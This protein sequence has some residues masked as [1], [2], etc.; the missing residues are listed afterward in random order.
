MRIHGVAI[1]VPLLSFA[2]PDRSSRLWQ[3]LAD[4]NELSGLSPAS[5]SPAVNF[6][7]RL[8]GWLRHRPS[9]RFGQVNLRPKV[10][11]LRSDSVTSS[12]LAA[13]DPAFDVVLQEGFF[14]SPK[15]ASKPYAVYIDATGS[16]VA[17]H[18]PS[19]CPWIADEGMGKNWL[20]RERSLYH[21]AIRV[22]CYSEFCRRSVIYDYGIPEDKVT[23]LYPGANRQAVNNE[24]KREPKQVLFV[25]YDFDRKGG[26]KLLEAWPLVRRRVPGAELN[27]V[28]P[29]VGP[30]RCPAGVNFIGKVTNPARLAELYASASVFCMPSLFEAYGHVFIEAMSAG[31]PC[32]GPS[33]FAAPEIIDAGK[34]GL[35]VQPGV[36]DEIVEA[37]V[38]ILSDQSLLRDM[39]TAARL[40]ASSWPTWGMAAATISMQ[41]KQ[42][43]AKASA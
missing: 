40:K 43:L 22:F 1:G 2:R 28:G 12:I 13:S 17:R 32:I 5:L 35:L 24:N 34:D 8:Y 23:T 9:D 19:Q 20:Q 4:A 39:S 25:G 7:Y 15:S 41:L 27:I 42:D 16:I 31:L 38:R 33:A 18:Y 11:D 26:N 6:A 29:E 3:A 14:F 21:E 10:F 37:L 36:V 30:S